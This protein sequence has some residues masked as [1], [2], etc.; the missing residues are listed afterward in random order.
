MNLK[1]CLIRT[2]IVLLVV[3]VVLIV[4]VSYLQR[5]RSYILILDASVSMRERLY[6]ENI[7]KMDAA[8]DAISRFAT[9]LGEEDRVGLVVFYDCDDIRVELPPG[10]PPERLVD[11]VKG[12]EPDNQ[13]PIAGAL[14]LVD[15]LLSN[16]T[17]DGW[18]YHVVLITDGVEFCGGD[19]LS[20]AEDLWI[21]SGERVRID[22]VSVMIPPYVE[23]VTWGIEGGPCGEPTGRKIPVRLIYIRIVEMTGGTFVDVKD[24]ETFRHAMIKMT[25]SKWEVLKYYYWGVLLPLGL[26]ICLGLR[27]REEEWCVLRC[28]SLSEERRAR[29]PREDDRA[30]R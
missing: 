8:K 13:T 23:E 14:R 3:W 27:A 29:G 9:A 5:P 22:V 11:T 17:L 10:S 18:E 21:H 4:T 20:A 12:V 28:S 25:E 1:D 15:R 6:P 7:S 24:V 16:L 26:L 19:P 30:M 2:L